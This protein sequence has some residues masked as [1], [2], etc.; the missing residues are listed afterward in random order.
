M[1]DEEKIEF[2][3]MLNKRNTVTAQQ[4]IQIL[5]EK[6]YEQEQKITGLHL[7]VQTLSERLNSLE[8]MTRIQKVMLTGTGPTVKE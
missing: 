6:I 4:A 1:N 5:Q 2:S 3:Q 7:T 8:L